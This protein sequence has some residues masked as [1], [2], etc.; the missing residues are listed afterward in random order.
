MVVGMIKKTL[1]LSAVL[2][3]STPAFSMATTLSQSVRKA[4]NNLP[5][6]AIDIAN[7]K[8]NAETIKQ[9][10]AAYLP[11][12]DLSAGYGREYAKN[13]VQ[14]LVDDSNSATLNRSEFRV[15]LTENIFEGF[16]TVYEVKRT[17]NETKAAGYQVLSTANDLT[18]NVV[19]Q[20]LNVILQKKLVA[21]S[22]TNLNAHKSITGMIS[23]R[24]K[25]GVAR[26]SELSQSNTRTAL[27]Q[28]NLITEQSNLEDANTKYQR[29]VG[30]KPVNLI[31]PPTPRYP[32]I[33]KIEQQAIDIALATHPVLKTANADIAAAFAQHGASKF[34][35]YPKLDLVLEAMKDKNIDGVEG[36]QIND[37]AMLRV[38][39]NLFAGGA[40]IA[41]QRQTAFQVQEAIAIRN[42]AILQ[43]TEAVRLAW[44][45][46]KN[47]QRRVAKLEI[48]RI[49]A[50]KTLASYEEEFKL[51][52]RTLLDTLDAQNE[53]YQANISYQQAR[54][55]ELFARYRLLNA[56]GKLDR[57]LNVAV[58]Q[59][60]TLPHHYGY[61]LHA[62]DHKKYQ[63]TR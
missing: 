50:K 9:A 12:V 19:E 5:D 16:N 54:F 3:L 17:K 46:M 40:H 23:E 35:N 63:S 58:K 20:Y 28:T 29:Y 24:Q 36:R 31:M 60:L 34:T 30:V 13:P 7:E 27:A 47:E 4:L 8:A 51:N 15:N 39:Y 59:A 22:Y 37:L 49:E 25:A 42:R 44:T 56:M 6:L 61:N 62:M 52:K 45:A 43:T 57:Y 41:T 14:T 32:S 18:L 21:L 11:T 33:P 53:L 10:R 1:F 38:S 26:E 48:Y 55:D 2:I